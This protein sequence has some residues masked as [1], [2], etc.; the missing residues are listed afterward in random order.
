MVP[1]IFLIALSPPAAIFSAEPVCPFQDSK[2]RDVVAKIGERLAAG[3]KPRSWQ[4]RAHSTTSYLNS[5]W[6]PKRTMTAEKI[7]TVDGSFWSEE[8]IRAT[9]TEGGRTR[10]VTKTIQT[11]ARKQAEKQRRSTE[12]ER[13]NVQRSRGRRSLDLTREE[14]L[15]FGPDERSGY[16][17]TSK[18]LAEFDG[19]PV[20]LL[21]SRSLIR[22][23]E[24]LEGLYYIDPETFDVLRAELTIARKPAPL[25]RMEIDVDFQILPGGYQVMRK[26]VMRLHVGI[27]IKEIRIEAVETFSDYLIR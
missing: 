23:E 17:F 18:G 3:P 22:S 7:V 19:A 11:E 24:K 12:D 13:R 1:A 26:A 27:V 9:E 20:I 16:E 4:A 8:I 10:D 14:V 6:K 2:V 5:E 21:Q 25:K 15:P